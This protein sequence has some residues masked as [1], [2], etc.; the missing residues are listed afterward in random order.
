MSHH[1]PEN[2]FNCSFIE[3]PSAVE[4]PTASGSSRA[5]FSS[6]ETTEDGHVYAVPDGE[7]PRV[8]LPCHSCMIVSAA[9]KTPLSVLSV[10]VP[11]V[12]LRTFISA[13]DGNLL[14]QMI[15][16]NMWRKVTF[17]TLSSNND[18]NVIPK[19]RDHFGMTEHYEVMLSPWL[20]TMFC[21]CMIHQFSAM[22]R[23]LSK[24]LLHSHIRCKIQRVIV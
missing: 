19:T 12:Y 1:D 7:C 10:T 21:F 11:P 5:S 24:Q 18:G 20:H 22:T 4:Q 15:V 8:N 13:G 16:Q 17:F 2:T 9:L 14:R 6:V 3:P 23:F